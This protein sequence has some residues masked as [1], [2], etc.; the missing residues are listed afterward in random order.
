MV[1]HRKKIVQLILKSTLETLDR[2]GQRGLN[3]NSNG[4][5]RKDLPKSTDLSVYSQEEL[6][7]IAYKWNSIPR[8][9]LDY[10]TPNEVIKEAF[11]FGLLPVV[12]IISNLSDLN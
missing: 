12:V 4:I 7:M 6:N 10:K 3:E 2:P 1:R 8:K 9:S 5:V 11:G